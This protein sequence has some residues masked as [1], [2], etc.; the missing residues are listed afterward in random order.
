M[1]MEQLVQ[2]PESYY[3]AG[4]D[5]SPTLGNLPNPH[6]HHRI[7]ALRQNNHTPKPE[8]EKTDEEDQIAT[9][10]QEGYLDRTE[11]ESFIAERSS[12]LAAT[13]QIRR[14][15]KERESLNIRAEQAIQRYFAEHTEPPNLQEHPAFQ[16]IHQ[17]FELSPRKDEEQAEI[18]PARTAGG[19]RMAQS[20]DHIGLQ[21]APMTI[22]HAL[23]KQQS[24]APAPS[25]GL[26]SAS[27]A[28]QHRQIPSKKE[29]KGSRVKAFLARFG[30]KRKKPAD[31]A[32]TKST[33]GGLQAH[34]AEQ[35]RVAE[36]DCRHMPPIELIHRSASGRFVHPTP[37]HTHR[38]TLE[39]YPSG[40][41]GGFQAPGFTSNSG[42]RVLRAPSRRVVA[43]GSGSPRMAFAA[44]PASD[45]FFRRG[46]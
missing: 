1:S 29:P 34:S 15:R 46:G 21:S 39:G 38:A 14:E 24:L 44:A 8:S 41:S 35:H 6:L 10:I 23:K 43:S 4:R 26:Q 3:L 31:K 17:S 9:L 45:Y 32:V 28:P 2:E 16:A 20:H 30:I 37:T 36:A 27:S 33:G 22:P 19:L 25:H 7:S 11:Q 18:E 12:S 13:E 42:P 5:D 40:E